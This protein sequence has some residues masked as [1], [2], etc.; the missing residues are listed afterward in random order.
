MDTWGGRR[1]LLA[2]TFMDAAK[3]IIA[4]AFA[5]EFFLKFPFYSKFGIFIS[6]VV[7]I[8]ISFFVYPKGAD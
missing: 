8:I 6:L 4:A 2:K 7:A 1:K 5:S 3:I